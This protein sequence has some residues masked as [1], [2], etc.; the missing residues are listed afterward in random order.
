MRELGLLSLQDAVY[1][2]SGMPARR[3]GLVDRGQIAAGKA[4]DLVIFDPET[5]ADRSTWQEP[6]LS[7]IGI[8]R[9]MVNGEWVVIEGTPTGKLPGRVLR[10]SS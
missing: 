10:R 4:A 3:F 2:M 6:R 8:D 9:V 1:K 7:P 5:V